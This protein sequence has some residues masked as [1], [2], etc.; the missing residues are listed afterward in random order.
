MILKKVEQARIKEI[1]KM[2]EAKTRMIFDHENMEIDCSR[3]RC[4]DAKHNTRIVLPGPLKPNKE[5]EL[6]MRRLEWM[7]VYDQYVAEF[8]D[9][10]GVQEDN[11]T[12]EEAGGLKSLKKRVAEGSLIICQTDKSG[13]FAVMSQEE[14]LAAGMKHVAKDEEVGLEFMQKNQ[15]RLNG[16]MSMILKTFNV[17]ASWNHQARIR[18]TKLT[19]SLSVAPLYL[20]YKDHKGWTIETG[21]A[22]PTRPVASSGGGQDDHLSE[23]VSQI[24]EP[25]ANTWTGGMETTSTQDF[26]SKI[27]EL[28]K[29]DLEL[30]DI[31]LESVDKMFKEE[32]ERADSEYTRIEGEEFM[33]VAKD[34]MN[35]GSDLGVGNENSGYGK[36]HFQ[37]K[38]KNEEMVTLDHQKQQKTENVP[39]DTKKTNIIENPNSKNNV[40]DTSMNPSIISDNEMAPKM[41]FPMPTPE[42]YLI[43]DMLDI[44]AEIRLEAAGEEDQL[45]G[46]DG[47]GVMAPGGEGGVGGGQVEGAGQEIR[48]SHETYHSNSGST[49]AA[50]M[51]KYRQDQ[52]KMNNAR[53]SKLVRDCENIPEM[54]FKKK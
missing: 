20:L 50:N 24:L 5:R 11:L 22:P 4:T 14:Y 18:A 35:T 43:E 7:A 8:C 48:E 13:R 3:Q 46:C 32:E 53:K 21:D 38:K 34:E 52:H 27:V 29:G 51:K 30:E 9:E 1:G 45:Q 33:E 6:E 31:D 12:P 15:R 54:V 37:V 39:L 42:D 26:V 40:C 25:V 41:S 16:H 36:V 49:R 19:Y 23:T 2:E 28:N 47:G 17:G 44:E 10:H